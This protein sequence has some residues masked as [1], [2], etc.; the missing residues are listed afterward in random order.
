M[1]TVCVVNCEFSCTNPHSYPY[2]LMRHILHVTILN[3]VHLD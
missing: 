1:D 3:R 2:A